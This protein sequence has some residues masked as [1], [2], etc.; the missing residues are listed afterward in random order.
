MPDYREYNGDVEH[1]MLVDYTTEMYC[2]DE[3]SDDD[4]SEYDAHTNDI[5]NT[6]TETNYNEADALLVER[7]NK[8][9]MGISIVS[10]ILTICIC[11]VAML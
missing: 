9:A 8:V 6:E 5:F 4:Y 11:I 10:V 7:R 3:Y 2:E 1:D